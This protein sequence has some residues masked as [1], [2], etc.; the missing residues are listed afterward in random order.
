MQ[1]SEESEHKNKA[2]K[3]PS[4]IPYHVKKCALSRLLKGKAIM[5]FSEAPKGSD[6]WREETLR[7]KTPTEAIFHKIYD[8]HDNMERKISTDQTGRFPTKSYRGM[9][10][11]MISVELD[12]NAIL[13]EAMQ[14]RTSGDMI[15]PY[16]ILVNQLKWQGLR[17]KMHILDNECSADFKEKILQNDMKYQLV[18]PHD[19]RRN[20][21]EKIVQVFKAFFVSV[22]CGADTKFPMQRWC[23]ILRQAE[24]QLNLL[25]KSRVDPSKSRYATPFAPLGC[26][27]E[28]HVVPSKRK[29]WEAHIKQ[30]ITLGIH[31]NITDAMK[32]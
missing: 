11:I 5:A 16:Q 6:F 22:L 20:V 24:H 4:R 3:K 2:T 7:Y 10:Y 27:V 19:H 26:V 13:V 31:G 28:M 9:Q 18:P 8:L 25:Q 1:L 15:Q 14:D 30:A 17:P 29:T 21:A 32:S 12:S 23:Q